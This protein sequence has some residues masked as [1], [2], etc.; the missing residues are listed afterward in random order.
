MRKRFD[1]NR[2]LLERLILSFVL[3]GIAGAINA[4][5]F[6]AVGTYTSHMTGLVARIGDELAS[7]NL[8]LA[9]WALLFVAAFI[10][11]AMTATAVILHAKRHGRA[12]YWRP[13]LL[14]SA[15]LFV[16]ATVSVGSEHGAQLNSLEMTSLLCF[17]MGL[18]NALVTKLSGATVRTTHLTGIST[19]IGI[20]TM[21]GLDRWWQATRGQPLSV[22]LLQRP[23]LMEDPQLRDL[24]RHLAIWT[25]FLIG[26]TAGP[27]L[28]L[29]IGHIAMLVPCLLLMGLA[30]FDGWIG[31]TGRTLQP[32]ATTGLHGSAS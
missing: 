8:W 22:R 11:G 23:Q 25:S 31:L 4:S 30:F 24:R 1:Q 28:Y 20:E 3:P 21:R 2:P 7:G 14:E 17:A 29:T 16:F 10:S 12:P 6:F 26:A 27:A 18:Q 15:L 5:G 19:D 13:L 9:S 32:T